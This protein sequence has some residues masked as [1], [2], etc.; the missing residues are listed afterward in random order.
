MLW[1]HNKEHKKIAF[2]LEISDLLCSML[3]D[4]MPWP[5]YLRIL[6]YISPR[7]QILCPPSAICPLLI[8]KR[9]VFSDVLVLPLMRPMLF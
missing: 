2:D 4:E 1:K 5:M 6:P 9:A 3:K 8:R 7:K